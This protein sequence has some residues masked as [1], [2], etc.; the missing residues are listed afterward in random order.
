MFKNVAV[1]SHGYTLLASG[2]RTDK[3]GIGR[4]EW[5]H[6]V[7]GNEERQ[8]LGRIPH[9]VLLALT[10]RAK[11]LIFGTGSSC[12][13]RGTTIT[14]Q[15]WEARGMPP[16]VR[17]EAEVAHKTTL[18]RFHDLTRFNALQ[19]AIIKFGQNEAMGY[20]EKI[21]LAD[22]NCSNTKGEIANSLKR[23]NLESIEALISVTSRSHAP[24]CVALANKEILHKRYRNLF[25]IVSPCDTDFSENEDPL[26]FEPQ[27]GPGPRNKLSP[28][29]VLQPYFNL[30]H[31]KRIAFLKAIKKILQ[32]L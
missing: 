12:I 13:F 10:Y 28:S 24:R 8:Q 27:S 31:E 30:S 9:G 11:K 15:D 22:I 25:Y 26:I 14:R 21:A 2:Q 23:C 4:R 1:L 3:N 20:I 19:Q 17:W 16:Q 7:W 6:V 29:A 5:S 32:N 18:D